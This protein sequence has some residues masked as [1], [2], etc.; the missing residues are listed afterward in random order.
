MLSTSDKAR[1]V[2]QPAVNLPD[3]LQR[4]FYFSLAGLILHLECR[5][6][7]WPALPSIVQPRRGNV[8]M[9]QPLLHLCNVGIVRER[10]GGSCG[11]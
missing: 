7:F 8:G 6:L 10:I 9:P 3:V 5:A 1:Y 4:L 11:T 2:N